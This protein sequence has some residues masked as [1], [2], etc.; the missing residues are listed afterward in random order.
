M[1]RFKNKFVIAGIFAVG[2]LAITFAIT[3]R[4]AV[5]AFGSDPSPI[6]KNDEVIQAW[7][8]QK[9]FR[10]IHDLYDERVVFVTT[11]QTVKVP[12]NPFF[13]DPIFNQ[14]FGNQG[15]HGGQPRTQKR[16]GLGS[17]F[18]I[19][20]DGY[21]ATN[22]HVVEGADK[23]TVRIGTKDYKADVIG[24]DER[25]DVALIKISSPQK[26]KPVFFGNSDQVQ[27]G[28][29]AIAIGNPYGLSKT[30]T[31]GVISAVGR[32]DPEMM[33][34]TMSL[35]QTDASINRGNSGGPLI[36]IKGEVVGIN[37]MIFSESGGSVGIGFAIPINTAKTILEQLKVDKKIRRGYIG[38]QIVPLT[39]DH[40][41]EI[42]LSNTEGALVGG[43][44]ADS[45]AQ[46]SGVLVGDVIIKAGDKKIAVYS[47]LIGTVEATPIGKSLK[48]TVWRNKSEV[49]L[50]A[51]IKERP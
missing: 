27:V 11:E 41:K 15:N 44:V 8:V 16:T 50:F 13:D 37:N 12:S 48:I 30:F 46:K 2:I 17:G 40:A 45:P 35:I 14:M 25:T 23:V 20:E 22:N 34:G 42:G 3:S 18:I 21:I 43:I 5:G 28:D 29:W 32:N 10:S 24:K 49:T 31:V 36:N 4:G 9:A 47:D 38:V 6:A 33:G 39:E 19:S 26:F 1:K 7:N 51:T